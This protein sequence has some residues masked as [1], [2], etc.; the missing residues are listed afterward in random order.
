MVRLEVFDFA[1]KNIVLTSFR[2]V[3]TPWVVL[4]FAACSGAPMARAPGLVANTSTRPASNAKIAWNADEHRFVATGLPAVTRDGK[5]AIVAVSGGDGGRGYP[6][7][8]LEVRDR[9]DRLVRTIAVVDA[10]HWERLAPDGTP[11]PE[12]TT[13]VGEINR[14]LGGYDLVA[15]H[16]FELQRR[17][18]DAAD[19]DAAN[20]DSLQAEWGRPPKFGVESRSVTIESR[21]AGIKKTIDASIWHGPPQT[22]H[23][24]PC[25][26]HSY[27]RE[28]YDASDV[29]LIIVDVAFH[30]TDLCWE[31]ADQW[32]VVSW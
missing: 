32:H 4:A 8:H 20:G 15:M 30:G 22:A 29:R 12:L 25:D 11:G 26:N 28:L 7:V 21:R 9:D 3:P 27:L 2:R 10:N 5:L 14:E 23:G 18:N 6:N 19:R 24:E 31:P 17:D 16:S 1:R 13:H